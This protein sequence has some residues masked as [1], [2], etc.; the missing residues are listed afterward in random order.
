MKEAFKIGFDEGKEILISVFSISL[1]LSI[2]TN[3]L[4]ILGNLHG[5]AVL[6][7]VFFFTIGVGF[8]LHE[9]AH[10]AVAISYG[11]KA[12]FVMWKNGI[13]FMFITSLFGILFAAP[14]AVYI[15]GKN[16]T[17]RENGIIAL[18]GPVTNMIVASIFAV[19]YLFAPSR[20]LQINI[21][22]LGAYINALLAAFN[23]IP[24][25]VLDGKK[26]KDWNFSVW[27]AVFA[28]SVL[29]F[30]MFGGLVLP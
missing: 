3:G 17:K 24:F 1:A 13:I 5:L 9:L 25:F 14:G 26:V 18:A 4:G 2:A 21:W 22:G 20:L 10:K 16:I 19:F 30:L 23:L 7:V 15:M 27:L 12:R 29:M 11:A 8:V 28:V 6:M